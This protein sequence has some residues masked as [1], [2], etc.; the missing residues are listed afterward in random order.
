MLSIFV[1][2]YQGMSINRLQ[3]ASTIDIRRRH[4]FEAYVRQM[5]K[6]RSI[7]SQYSPD[8]SIQWLTRIAQLMS[9]Q[10]QMIFLI[11][12][13]QPSWL[14]TIFQRWLYGVFLH[15]G[16]NLYFGVMLGLFVGIIFAIL[17]GNL[18][19][20]ISFFLAILIFS[21]IRTFSNASTEYY[22]EVQLVEKVKWSLPKAIYEMR[23]GLVFLFL[24]G[25]SIWL[26]VGPVLVHI[27]L[28]SLLILS[29]IFFGLHN[30]EI[31]TKTKPNE[32]VISTLQNTA[33]IGFLFGIGSSLAIWV[34][35]R[36]LHGNYQ[37]D[38]PFIISL[39]LILGLAIAL[40][41]AM[42]KGG[43]TA[44]LKHYIIRF[45]LSRFEFLPWNMVSFLDYA[46]ERI[47]MRKVGG[48]YIFTHRLLQEYFASLPS[49][50]PSRLTN[51]NHWLHTRT[52]QVDYWLAQMSKITTVVGKAYNSNKKIFNFA[53]I[54][55][56]LL[57]LA[58]GARAIVQ[59]M[60]GKEFIETGIHYIEASLE[61]D[62]ADSWNATCL[63]GVDS[64]TF[65]L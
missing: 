23:E 9:R 18:W 51:L 52:Q 10:S 36:L 59:S 13:L 1:L 56:I 15:F 25:L 38:A 47:F 54:I 33:L 16:I 7:N 43:G 29:S 11:E 28:L 46:T 55:S 48:G 30:E 57:L 26:F 6:R 14:P 37:N 19:G 34:I 24:S 31:E 42:G 41:S 53:I 64:V 60:G 4:L 35:I 44:A 3:A 20:V 39:S 2:A 50:N 65:F 17:L 63:Q 62:N 22:D 45:I 32:G 58:S 40:I 27:V 8:Q 61:K 49:R 5:F 21:Y 12:Y